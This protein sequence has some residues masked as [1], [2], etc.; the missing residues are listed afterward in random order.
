M[1]IIN[2]QTV[3]AGLVGVLPSLAYI[4]TSDPLATVLV[5]GYLNHVVQNGTSFQ[6]PCI[7]AVST[8]ETPTSAARIG[9]F[10]ISHSGANW[11]LVSASSPAAGVVTLPTIL[12]HIAIYSDTSGTLAEN[13]STAINGGNIQAGLSGT[14]G[15]LAS[16]PATLAKG[17]L[18][19][20]AVANTGDTL[21]TISN[22]LHGQASVYS[23]PDSGA[24][25][26]N[27]IVSKLNGTQHITVGNLAVDAGTLSS[28]IATGGTAG[29]LLLYPATTTTGSLRL[30][31][32]GNV[33]NFATTVSDITGLG[34]AQV[35]TIPDSGAATAKF[36]LDTGTA[37][38]ASFNKL[39]VGATPV[40]V[41]DPVS[42]TITAVAGAANTSTITVTLKD[43]AGG[44]LARRV[45]FT[46]YASSAA[47]G[48]TLAAA[49]STGFSV[50]SGGLSLANGT[51]VTTQISAMSSAS[52]AC[53][54]SL[55]DT[56]KQ[57][58]YLVLVVGQGTK[59]SA[60]LSAGSY[61]A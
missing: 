18:R 19:L 24:S 17:S 8:M 48:L 9:W 13:A 12:N 27:F 25:T 28:G 51:A 32:V 60:Q 29:G 16:F 43:G 11:S 35:V 23:I 61:G 49:A 50:E 34:Q 21:V 14:A 47:D 41:V 58:S 22:A 52:G 10:A 59:I 55:L 30:V 44:T 33:G 42:C 53:V 56:G 4:E 6:L 2:V 36:L 15:Y 38:T 40:P 26:A 3:Q 7:A 1:G 5:A 57:T 45:P 46:V 31:P 20:T 39:S 54:L 37:A